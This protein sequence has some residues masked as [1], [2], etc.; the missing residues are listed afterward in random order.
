VAA[1]VGAFFALGAEY[2]LTRLIGLVLALALAAGT[3]FAVFML[4]PAGCRP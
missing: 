1:F 2:V 4:L 3:F